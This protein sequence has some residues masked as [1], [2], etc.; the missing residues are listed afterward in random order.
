MDS[1]IFVN[2]VAYINSNKRIGAS[3]LNHKSYRRQRSSQA[4]FEAI[5][6]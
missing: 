3:E 6:K 5:S 2:A 4:N 1:R